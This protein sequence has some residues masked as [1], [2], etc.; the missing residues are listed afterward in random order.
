MG[1]EEL[2]AERRTCYLGVE[3]SPE[4][5]RCLVLGEDPLCADRVFASMT[6][7]E[8]M[9]Y[10]CQISCHTCLFVSRKRWPHELPTGSKSTATSYK[11]LEA[12]MRVEALSVSLD[13]ILRDAAGATVLQF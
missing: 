12:M 1:A 13:I 6:S 2:T 4:S 11:L 10:D 9:C 8:E 3:S 7:R 5:S